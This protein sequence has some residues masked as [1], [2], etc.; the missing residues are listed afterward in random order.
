MDP[1][2]VF[3][4]AAFVSTLVLGRL[5]SGEE[6]IHFFAGLVP[7]EDLVLVLEVGANDAS[8]LATGL[9][10]SSYHCRTL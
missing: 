3:F 1:E 8:P 7:N 4:A 2:R 10:R 9:S 6:K 5:M